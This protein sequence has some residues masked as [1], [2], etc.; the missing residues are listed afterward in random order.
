MFYGVETWTVKKREMDR[1]EAF[2]LWTYRRI[3][4][5]SWKDKVTNDEVMRRMGKRKEILNTVKIRKLQYL[6]HVMRGEKYHLLQLVIQGKLQ[7]KRRPGRRRISW[8]D[9]LKTW[10]NCSTIE[11]FRAAS[12]KA[13]VSMMVANLLRGDGT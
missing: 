6:G 1:L 12:S 9:N 2:E 7:G 10:F 3:L 5:L 8:I 4:R 11:L 13:R